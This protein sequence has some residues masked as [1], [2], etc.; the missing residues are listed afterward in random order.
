M[1]LEFIIIITLALI[2][3]HFYISGVRVRKYINKIPG[4][5]AWPIIG[6]ALTFMV[7]ERK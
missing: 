5:A 2:I 3:F 4:P 6:N 1:L 7:S